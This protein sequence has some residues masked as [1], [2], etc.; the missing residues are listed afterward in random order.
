VWGV[1]CSGRHGRGLYQDNVIRLETRKPVILSGNTA[2][3]RT[4]SVSLREK[5]IESVEN[6]VL[7]RIFEPKEEEVRGGWGK[8]YTEDINNL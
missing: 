5:H 8:L 2:D 4:G 6:R 7:R 1:Q 3:L